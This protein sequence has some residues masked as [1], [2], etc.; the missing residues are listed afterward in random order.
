LRVYRGRAVFSRSLGVA[1]QRDAN[2]AKG[3]F[4]VLPRAGGCGNRVLGRNEQSTQVAQVVDNGGEA[5]GQQRG[6]AQRDTGD[7]RGDFTR[8]KRTTK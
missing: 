3:D 7:A 8:R 6:A 5:A 2:A 1:A 4:V